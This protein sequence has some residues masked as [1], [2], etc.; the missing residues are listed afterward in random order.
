MAYKEDGNARECQ[1]TKD[2]EAKIRV[3]KGLAAFKHF[4]ICKA[5]Q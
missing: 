4:N 2:I 1:G 3:K 5:I